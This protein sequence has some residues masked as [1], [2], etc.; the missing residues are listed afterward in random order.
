MMHQC[1]VRGISREVTSF[2]SPFTGFVLVDEAKAILLRG[3]IH[4]KV[5]CTNILCA[6]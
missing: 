4:T 3:L 1:T 2:M 6:I 5:Y